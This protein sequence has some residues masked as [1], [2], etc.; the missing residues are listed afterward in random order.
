MRP[1]S[2]LTQEFSDW[3]LENNISFNHEEYVKYIWEVP[4]QAV[5]QWK[6]ELDDYRE[7]F[8]DEVYQTYINQFELN[9]SIMG[10]YNIVHDNSTT[11]KLYKLSTSYKEFTVKDILVTK[12][13]QLPIPSNRV[14][15]PDGTSVNLPTSIEHGS[16]KLF[17]PENKIDLVDSILDITR[18]SLTGDGFAIGI[19]DE[20]KL[21]NNSFLA[22]INYQSGMLH[23]IRNNDANEEKFVRYYKWL[24]EEISHGNSHSCSAG[25]SSNGTPIVSSFSPIH[26]SSQVIPYNYISVSGSFN[27]LGAPLTL[28]FSFDCI[29]E[30]EDLEDEEYKQLTSYSSNQASVIKQIKEDLDKS[31]KENQE[32]IDNYTGNYDFQLGRVIDND[33][34]SIL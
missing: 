33:S 21:N 4:Q 27:A 12:N 30:P 3:L 16:L 23:I 31:I 19:R 5:D 14:T 8:S 22:T 28:V 15:L 20:N 25:I 10:V 34:V 29:K 13:F 32:I 26:S 1:F 6:T 18:G 17:T 9:G 11:A 7:L 2:D 24:L